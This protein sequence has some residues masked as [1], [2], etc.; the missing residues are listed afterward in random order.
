[1]QANAPAKKRQSFL[2]VSRKL[3]LVLPRLGTCLTNF[4]RFL[5]LRIRR[6]DG[7][8]CR[9]GQALVSSP[10]QGF[11]SRRRIASRPGFVFGF[12]VLRRVLRS[13]SGFDAPENGWRP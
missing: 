9:V 5:R 8:A 4:L 2:N 10:R 12:A 7:D 13:E 6:W 3:S 11:Y 1:M